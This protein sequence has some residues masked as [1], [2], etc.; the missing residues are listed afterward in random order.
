MKKLLSSLIFTIAASV[1]TA[2]QLSLSPPLITKEAVPSGGTYSLSV[3]LPA[4]EHIFAFIP[5]LP[6]LPV[7][8]AALVDNDGQPVVA[9]ITAVT[10]SDDASRLLIPYDGWVVQASGLAPGLYRVEGASTHNDIIPIQVRIIGSETGSLLFVGHPDRD[11]RTGEPLPLTVVVAGPG[12]FNTTS[13]VTYRI[14][15]GDTLINEATVLDNGENGDFTAEDGSYNYLFEPSDAG[16]YLLEVELYNTDSSNSNFVANLST[17]FTVAEQVLSLANGFVETTP[18]TDFDGYFDELVITYTLDDLIPPNETVRL[19]SQ[20]KVGETLIE[21]FRAVS[22]PESSLSSHFDGKELRAAG[23]DGEISIEKTVVVDSLGA[24]YSSMDGG[25]TAFYRADQWERE[26]LELISELTDIAV[27]ENGDGFQDRIDINFQIDSIVAGEFGMSATI[28]S[29]DGEKIGVIGNAATPLVIGENTLTLSV[30]G[31]EFAAAGTKSRLEVRNLFVYPNSGGDSL[32]QTDFVGITESTYDCWDFAGCTN[33]PN[34]EP[35]AVDDT[36]S[37]NGSETVID[38]VAND[39]D[40]D[41]DLLAVREIGT[42]TNGTAEIVGN[43]VRYT[44]NAGFSGADSFTYLIK[45]VD[46]DLYVWKGGSSTATVTVEVVINNPPIANDDNYTV[47]SGVQKQLFVLNNDSDADGDR[48]YINAVTQPVTGSVA[49]YGNSVLI[50][51]PADFVGDLSFTYTVLDVD[52]DTNVAKGGSDSA[53]VT[54]TVG[55]VENRPPTVYC[56]LIRFD[57][58][59]GT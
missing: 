59:G 50:E 26:D 32:L 52:N 33:G 44:P 16:E 58:I 15:D 47:A 4:S 48:L 1:S 35:L 25:M 7:E 28:Y 56:S 21:D 43:A 54:V 37:S 19:Y 14:F 46:P 53:T 17:T 18:D 10:A 12:G 42:P 27:D 11:N 49:N 3:Q 2:D 38:V 57:V 22:M 39:V 45:D 40:A 34:T 6:T 13:S 20:I 5:N 29:D 9:T 24:R 55:S 23:Y 41:G 30:P 36:A 31:R 8:S 51:T